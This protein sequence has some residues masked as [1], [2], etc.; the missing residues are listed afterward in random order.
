MSNDKQWFVY[1]ARCADNSLYCGVTNNLAM[2]MKAHNDGKG[3]KYTKSRRPVYLAFAAPMGSKSMALV[4]EAEYKKY[5]K[6]KKEKL[7][8]GSLRLS[9]CLMAGLL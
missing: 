5:S 7:V 2:R 8:N 3:A 1:M 9:P 6:A 4:A